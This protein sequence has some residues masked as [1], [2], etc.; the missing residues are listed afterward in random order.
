MFVIDKSEKLLILK[1]DN[2]KLRE[3]VREAKKKTK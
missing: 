1:E 2:I 3:N